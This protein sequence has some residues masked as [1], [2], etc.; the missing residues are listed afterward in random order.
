MNRQEI[1]SRAGKEI[2]SEVKNF[3]QHFTS[4][5][6]VFR[7]FLRIRTEMIRLNRFLWYELEFGGKI[8][9]VNGMISYG[10]FIISTAF[11]LFLIFFIPNEIIEA[12]VR[13]IGFKSVLSATSDFVDF[14]I[15]VKIFAV[16]IIFSILI[17][18][19][20]MFYMYYVLLEGIKRRQTSQFVPVILCK[21]CD[22]FV[23][24]LLF[25]ACNSFISYFIVVCI[26][27]IQIHNILVLLSLRNKIKDEK[28]EKLQI[29]HPLAF[30]KLS[31]PPPYKA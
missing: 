2:T 16:W 24:S 12:Y 19:F 15:L 4:N 9:A 27:V 6:Q 30:D 21:F 22:L 1:C 17:A 8:V 18:S 29:I 20:G 28:H 31:L 25:F 23:T 10:L 14:C 13:E 11:W 7:Q 3:R 26:N 5:R